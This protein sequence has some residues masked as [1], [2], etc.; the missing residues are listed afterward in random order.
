MLETMTEL[1]PVLRHI[2]ANPIMLW[3]AWIFTMCYFGGTTAW[4]QL[5]DRPTIFGRV[6]YKFAGATHLS[7]RI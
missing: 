6:C 1:T 2:V 7:S 4:S 3:L 5:T